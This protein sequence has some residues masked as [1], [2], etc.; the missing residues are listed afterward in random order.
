[1]NLHTKGRKLQLVRRLW[2]PQTLRQPG[3]AQRSAELVSA[4]TADSDAGSQFMELVFGDGHRTGG[5]GVKW[6]TSG[7]LKGSIFAFYGLI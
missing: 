1:M 2:H 7:L 4:L 3:G 6:I 5:E